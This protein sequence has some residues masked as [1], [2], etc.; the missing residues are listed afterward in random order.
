MGKTKPRDHTRRLIQQFIH[1]S[2]K[3]LLDRQ[4]FSKSSFSTVVGVMNTQGTRIKV[5]ENKGNADKLQLE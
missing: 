4:T 1:L 3:P 2:I 5:K